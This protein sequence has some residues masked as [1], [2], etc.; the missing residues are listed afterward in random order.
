MDSRYK[1]YLIKK[2]AT[3]DGQP[4]SDLASLR[5]SADFLQIQRN[6]HKR[7]GPPGLGKRGKKKQTRETVRAAIIK[8]FYGEASYAT[9]ELPRKPRRSMAKQAI[10]LL[11]VFL[12]LPLL[13][14][15]RSS[16]LDFRLHASDSKN[17]AFL[18]VFL[19]RDGVDNGS[20]TRSHNRGVYFGVLGGV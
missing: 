19:F 12:G 5:A 18:S 17:G 2:V 16:V 11:N 4:N 15:D 6:R 1:L 9:F 14:G 10:Y 20:H 7:T 3:I 13:R 8:E